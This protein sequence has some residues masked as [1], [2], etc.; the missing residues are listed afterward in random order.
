MQKDFIYNNYLQMPD[1]LDFEQAMKIYEELLKR[2]WKKM[3]HMI[4][5]GIMHFTA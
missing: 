4:N 5:Y 1:F 3:K 2:I